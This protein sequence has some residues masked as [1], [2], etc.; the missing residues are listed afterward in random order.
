M[1]NAV[2][3]LRA[4]LSKYEMM[5]REFTGWLVNVEQCITAL[6]Q[7]LTDTHGGRK[8]HGLEL[9]SGKRYKS[10]AKKPKSD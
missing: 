9:S 1:T 4:E 8:H 2:A 3:E 6:N 5:N 7:D 10:Y